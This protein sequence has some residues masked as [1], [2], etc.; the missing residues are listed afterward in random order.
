[1]RTGTG[2]RVVVVG[3]GLAGLSAALHLLGAGHEVTVLERAARPGGRAGDRGEAGYTIDTGASVFTMPELLDEA[4]DAVGESRQRW[5]RLSRVEPAY[6]AHFADGSSMRLHTDPEAMEAEIRSVAGPDDAEG[7]RRLRRWLTELYAVQRDRFIGANFDSPLDLLRPELVRLAMLGGFGRLGPAM[8]R[9]IG[10]ERVRKLFSFQ[11]LYA[12][13][14]PTRALAAY[15]VISYMDTVGGV[16]YPIG[17][18]GRV[19][20]G[21][22]AAAEKAGATLRFEAAVSELEWSGSR[23]RAVRTADGERS[24]CDHV[25]LATELTTAYALL[26][27]WPRRPVPLRFSP[28]AVVLHGHS[29]RTWP[30][31]DHHTIFFGRHWRRT[32]AEIIRDGTLMSDPSLLVTRPTATDPGLAPRGRQVISVLAPAPNLR[33]GEIDWARLAPAYRDELLCALTARGLTAFAET[34]QVTEVVTPDT[35]ARRGLAGG[36]PFSLAHTFAQTGPFRPA[37]LVRGAD[38]VV[39]AGCGTVPGVGIPPVLISGRLAAERIRGAADS[40]RRR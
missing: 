9:F 2:Q 34:M 27:R 35:W 40:R 26:G 25:V 24:R 22:A 17:G 29:G 7:Y 12:G 36:T 10:D 37:N 38:N 8:A 15:A 3:A 28:S 16:Y 18:M 4:F 33:A 31:L 19:A 20:A 14:D 1:M 6:R 11:S 23:V 5:V 21:M 32:F 13:L 30:Q 39:L